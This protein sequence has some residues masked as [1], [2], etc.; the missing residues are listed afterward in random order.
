[1]SSENGGRRILKS[2]WGIVLTWLATVFACLGLFAAAVG[3]LN[4][5]DWY[6]AL[7]GL[8]IVATLA[9]GMARTLEWP[10]FRKPPAEKK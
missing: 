3:L 4:D 10:P 5:G 8:P 1:M 9:W 2:R 7:L 6:L